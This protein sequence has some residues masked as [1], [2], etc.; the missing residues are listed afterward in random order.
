LSTVNQIN[1]ISNVINNAYTLR[2]VIIK[3][4]LPKKLRC[5]KLATHQ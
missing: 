5:A 2:A 3:E 4:N 1:D